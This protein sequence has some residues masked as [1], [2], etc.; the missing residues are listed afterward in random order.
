V[1]DAMRPLLV[2]TG[3]AG[4]LRELTALL[5]GMQLLSLRDVG[6]LDLREPG[7][8]YATNA[9]E[10]ALQASRATG[11]VTLAD[12]SGLEVDALGNAPG[13]RSARYG[14]EHGDDAANR[15]RLKA[16]LKGVPDSQRQARFRCAVALADAAGPLGGRVLL[17]FGTCYGRIAQVERGAHGFGYDPLLFV[18]GFGDATMAEL[19]DAVKNRFSHRARAVEAMRPVLAAYIAAR[20]ERP[21]P[22]T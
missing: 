1:I 4:K 18:D 16:A 12:D 22:Q 19:D 2:A 5:P 10:K 6:A 3:N 14:G 9:M 15:A 11:H 21:A 17:A 13:W 20:A 8:D 7:E